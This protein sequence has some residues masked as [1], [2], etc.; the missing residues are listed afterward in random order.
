MNTGIVQLKSMPCPL[1]SSGLGGDNVKEV[2]KQ[3]KEFTCLLSGIIHDIQQYC[4]GGGSV[5]EGHCRRYKH[6]E[7]DSKLNKLDYRDQS[8]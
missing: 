2:L 5:T 8:I 3:A 6:I 4:Q 7:R 1:R